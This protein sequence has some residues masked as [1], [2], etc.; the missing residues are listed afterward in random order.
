M[1]DLKQSISCNGSD[2][3]VVLEVT[4]ANA[5]DAIHFND[6]LAALVR[7]AAVPTPPLTAWL[8]RPQ[9]GRAPVDQKY[10]SD[11]NTRG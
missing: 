3:K 4:F 8:R 2:S 5:T 11:A 6:K 10:L 1:N 9:F 7:E